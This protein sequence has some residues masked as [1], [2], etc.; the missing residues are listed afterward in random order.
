[1]SAVS[2]ALRRAGNP[3]LTF[4]NRGEWRGIELR[5]AQLL[6]SAEQVDDV[7]YGAGEPGV[8]RPAS[9]QHEGVRGMARISEFAGYSKA[10]LQ[11]RMLYHLV[12]LT[13]PRD[14][15]EL[16][17][18]VGISA[19][20]LA[21]ALKRNGFGHL[22]TIEGSPQIAAVGS[23]TLAALGL[24]TVASVIRGPFHQTLAPTLAERTFDLVF[25]DG[26]HDGPATAGYF[27]LIR[28]RLRPGA[29]LLLDDIAWSVGM[30]AAWRRIAADPAVDESWSVSGIGAVTLKPSGVKI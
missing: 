3:L 27:E 22:W 5:R 11:C 28:P 26:H 19:A 21:A 4:L 29:I 18:C 2:N 9:F 10:P 14:V 6:Q 17:T 7:D 25:V 16:G 23:Q 15:L 12:R 30:Q 20:Y 1:M 13:R 24:G 8:P